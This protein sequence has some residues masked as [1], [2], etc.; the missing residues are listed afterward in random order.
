M[1]QASRYDRLMAAL[2]TSGLEAERRKLVEGLSGEVCEIGY[3]TGLQ[4]PYYPEGCR[5]T[6]V[7]PDAEFAKLAP[8]RAASAQVPVT[9]VAAVGEALPFADDS[10]DAV[11]MAMVLCS[12]GDMAQ[13]LAEARRVLK[14]GGRLRCVEH[15]RGESLLVAPLLWLTNPLWRLINRQGCNWHRRPSTAITEAGFRVESVQP[16]PIKRFGLHLLPWRQIR[17]VAG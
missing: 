9:L 8:A 12:V 2:A 17:A 6:G 1:S 10:F 11:V 13:V 4:L 14:P 15:V 5:V 7:E 16:A 3:G